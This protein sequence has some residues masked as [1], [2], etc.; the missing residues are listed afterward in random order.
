[1]SDLSITIH[2]CAEPM[3][4]PGS[5]QLLASP[6][7]YIELRNFF[8]KHFDVNEFASGP[9]GDSRYFV[10]YVPIKNEEDDGER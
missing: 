10:R 4:K 1:M 2:L 5:A 6:K 3:C 9:M 8:A 7:D